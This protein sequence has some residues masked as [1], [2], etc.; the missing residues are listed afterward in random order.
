MLAAPPKRVNDIRTYL[1]TDI[2]RAICDDAALPV[3][4]ADRLA[5]IAVDAMIESARKIQ[6]RIT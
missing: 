4:D 5:E 6:I 2:S 3:V 1:I